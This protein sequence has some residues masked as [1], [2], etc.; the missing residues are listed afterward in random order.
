MKVEI[1]SG[2]INWYCYSELMVLLQAYPLALK[3]MFNYQ[4]DAPE[5]YLWADMGAELIPLVDANRLLK[6]RLPTFVLSC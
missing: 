3:I 1:V 2:L 4:F 5:R 6:G